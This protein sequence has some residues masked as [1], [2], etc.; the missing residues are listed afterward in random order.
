MSTGHDTAWYEHRLRILRDWHE[1]RVG[2]ALTLKR[3]MK[4]GLSAEKAREAMR[5]T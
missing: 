1:N 2:Y 4:L 5:A 3:L